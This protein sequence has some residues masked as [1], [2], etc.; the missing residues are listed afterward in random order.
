MN[1]LVTEITVQVISS[2][3]AYLIC[4]WLDSKF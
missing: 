4:K 3:I 1:E 2:V